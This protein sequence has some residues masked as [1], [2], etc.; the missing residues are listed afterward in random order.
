VA[1]EQV[2]KIAKTHDGGTSFRSPVPK[3]LMIGSPPLPRPPS[4]KKGAYGALA[5]NQRSIDQ[6]MNLKK[7][8]AADKE[9]P[10]DLN[11]PEKKF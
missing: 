9:V 5:S 6:S 2:A 11:N 7:K 1:Q 10:A 4:A 3:P 8:E